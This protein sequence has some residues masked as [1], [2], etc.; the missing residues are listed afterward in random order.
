MKF[1]ERKEDE[2]TRER[3]RDT[4][5][6][7]LEKSKTSATLKKKTRAQKEICF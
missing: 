4:G 6:Q 7:R 1:E 5:I 2:V 3:E